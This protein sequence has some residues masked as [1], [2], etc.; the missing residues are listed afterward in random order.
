MTPVDF[1]WVVCPNMPEHVVM[2]SL[3]FTSSTTM[4]SSHTDQCPLLT[5]T[6]DAQTMMFSDAQRPYYDVTF[7]EPIFF[8]LRM[9]QLGTHAA[10]VT[11]DTR[12]ARFSL[13]LLLWI[14]LC[15]INQSE[16]ATAPLNRELLNFIKRTIASFVLP[17]EYSILIGPGL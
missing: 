10:T 6:V 11:D 7:D 9:R 14:T 1:A 13:T 12:H 16:R 3:T 17:R 4:F 15:S 5:R 2:L 8:H